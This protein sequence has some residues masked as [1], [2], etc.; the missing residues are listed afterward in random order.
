M[1]YFGDNVRSKI[2]TAG[3]WNRSAA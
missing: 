3:I 2:M 1:V